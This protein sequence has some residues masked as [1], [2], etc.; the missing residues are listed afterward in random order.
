MEA[1]EIQRAISQFIRI[2]SIDF[3]IEPPKAVYA[4]IEKPYHGYYDLSHRTILICTAESYVILHEFVHYLQHESVG[5]VKIRGP[6]FLIHEAY[7]ETADMIARSL[8]KIYSNIF[9]DILSGKKVSPLGYRTVA[10]H[11]FEDLIMGYVR[12]I[13]R[14]LKML[15]DPS[16]DY[17]K[18]VDILL[19]I[20]N[21]VEKIKRIFPYF[22]RVR[23]GKW[24]AECKR[25][26]RNLE[27]IGTKIRTTNVDTLRR[28]GFD[29]FAETLKSYCD[30]FIEDVLEVI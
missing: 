19:G 4:D 13:E 10:R 26:L 1:P 25:L 18:K 20:E 12:T 28:H 22:C 11:L 15:G 8:N 7:E 16:I 23:F 9:A 21:E 24:D 30:A 2:L 5:W 27:I 29:K 6:E 17:E 14:A 3:R